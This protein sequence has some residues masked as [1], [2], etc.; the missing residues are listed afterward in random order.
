[1][2]FAA[3]FVFGLNASMLF[4]Q[5]ANPISLND[6]MVTVTDTVANKII[7]SGTVTNENG[8]GINAEVKY[9]YNEEYFVIKTDAQ[10]QFEFE[11]PSALLGRKVNLQ[12]YATGYKHVYVTTT[13]LKAKCYRYLIRLGEIPERNSKTLPIMGF[14]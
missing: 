13:D 1:M 14:F 2:A 6:S 4:G 8:V 9:F 5:T 10:G 11:M 3:I 12:F 7:V